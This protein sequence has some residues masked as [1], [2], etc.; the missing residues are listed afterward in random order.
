MDDQAHMQGMQE[1]MVMMNEMMA[2]MGEMRAR[3]QAM[4][5]GEDQQIAAG[6][7][8]AKGGTPAGMQGLMT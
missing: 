6:Y 1:M 5:G 4:T 3:M 2:K 8:R 7:D